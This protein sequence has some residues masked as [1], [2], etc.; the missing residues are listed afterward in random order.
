MPESNHPTSFARDDFK[1]ARAAAREFT[2]T[3]LTLPNV[4]G[5]G[6]ARRTVRGE[7]TDEWCFVTYVSRKLP[8][9]MLQSN[10]LIPREL[11]T[12]DGT[13]RTDVEERAR[14]EFFVDTTLYRP[15]K[16]GCQISTQSGGGTLGAVVYDSTD[17]Q[18][19]LLTCNHCLTLPSQRGTLP[20]G[21]SAQVRQPAM[22]L[23]PT[24]DITNPYVWSSGQIIGSTKRIVPMLPPLNKPYNLEAR[25]DA[26]IIAL[27]P[28]IDARFEVIDIG[29]HPYQVLPAYEGLR[30]VKRG[31]RT[32]RTEGIVE[33]IDLAFVVDDDNGLK[34]RI[35][36]PDY[37]F[38]IKGLG[39]KFAERGDSG[40]LVVDANGAAA[41]GMVF[42]G[43]RHASVF[44]RVYAC[45]LSAIFDELQLETPCNGSL[46][47]VIK[48]SV[49]RRHTDAW[50]EVA[51]AGG[52]LVREMV[53]KTDRFRDQYLSSVENGRVSGA[54]G[55]L[56]Q[57]L[58]TD[59]AEEISGNE[60]FAGLL[61]DAFGEWLVRPT[62]YDMLE[63][64]VSEDFSHRVLKAF[65]YLGERC[66]GAKGFE[67]VAV[68]LAKASGSTMRE[69]LAQEVPVKTT[70]SK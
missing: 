55:S 63:Y 46:H 29:K 10:E 22:S 34:Y 53:W 43:E 14:P 59:L 9:H 67:D 39:T 64:R 8:A 44:A 24:G 11:H 57:S 62:M 60:D 12:R 40:S 30:V 3:V 31:F 33:A 45:D 5:C 42:G 37:A 50:T 49:L 56:L 51:S 32:E 54:F 1:A 13:V 16:G 4:I 21:I 69:F 28:H 26:G 38:S 35:G 65:E 58:A 23:Q 17:F 15:L 36:G 52:G 61:E 7:Q 6:V 47:S 70:K 25:V 48:R 41:R 19:V 27:D 18:R 20:M 2:E 66:R 68:A